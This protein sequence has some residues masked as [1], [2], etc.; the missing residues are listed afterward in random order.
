MPLL[1]ISALA[2][3]HIYVL[4]TKIAAYLIDIGTNFK[5]LGTASKSTDVLFYI[6]NYGRVDNFVSTEYKNITQTTME[7]VEQLTSTENNE[8]DGPADL[9]NNNSN[10]K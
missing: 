8:N 5:I 3:K 1:S 10:P 7:V 4:F 6:N 9:E 2:E